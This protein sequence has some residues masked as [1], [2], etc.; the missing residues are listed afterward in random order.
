[1]RIAESLQN[2]TQSDDTAS[3]TD[4]LLGSEEGDSSKLAEKK[5]L[6]NIAEALARL[7]RV[8]R[9]GLGVEDKT[10]FIKAWSKSRRR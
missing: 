7:G 2:M 6:D 10:N 1:M 3:S 5:L 8:K 4:T 9:V